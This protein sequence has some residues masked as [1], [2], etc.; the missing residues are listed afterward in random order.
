MADALRV[1]VLMGSD[2][3]LPVMKKCLEQLKK[4]GIGYEVSVL[5][6][7]RTP[8]ACAQ[9][10]KEAPGRGIRVFIA[11]AGGAAHLAGVVAAHTVCPVIA[12]PIASTSLLG[13]DSLLAMVQMPPGIPVA[14][15]AIGDFGA[16]NAALLAA[17]I[18]ALSDETLHTRLLTHKA[19][20]EKK[21]LEKNEKVRKECAG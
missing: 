18:L 11:A 13:L 17:Q 21:V 9:Y 16:A 15:V 7:H 8:D 19:D 14:T 10:V 6:A 5:S 4:L 1:A 3:D 20:M 12:V 2:S